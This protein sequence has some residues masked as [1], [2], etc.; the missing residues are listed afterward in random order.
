[1]LQF[2]ILILNFL[3]KNLNVVLLALCAV[4]GDSEKDMCCQLCEVQSSKNLLLFLSF[5]SSRNLL[6]AQQF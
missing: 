4:F 3:I 6:L 2:F 5:E 1:M